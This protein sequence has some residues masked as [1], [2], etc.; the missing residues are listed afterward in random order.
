M[1]FKEPIYKLLARIRDKP[2]FKKSEPMGGDPKKY[3]QRW[4]CSFK[5]NIEVF[6]WTPYEMPRIDPNFIR[7]ELNVLPDT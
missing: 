3:N 6:A 5:A 4:K 2:Y 7:H 1:V